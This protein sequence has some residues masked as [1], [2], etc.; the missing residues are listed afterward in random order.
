[1]GQKNAW[2]KADKTDI[3]AMT[4]LG[5]NPG[6][7]EKF[8]VVKK[9]QVGDG[10]FYFK[11]FHNKYMRCVPDGRLVVDWTGDPGTWEEFMI[12]QEKTNGVKIY[13][14]QQGKYLRI[15]DGK[16]RCDEL[17]PAFA[18]LWTTPPV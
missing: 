10:I 4:H 11:T 3:E 8:N 15:A 5:S 13:N 2:L 9:S 12:F 6:A 7:W 16:V 14:P 18:T 17:R 1:M